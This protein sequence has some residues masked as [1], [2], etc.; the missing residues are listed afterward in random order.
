MKTEETSKAKYEVKYVI[1]VPGGN[2]TALVYGTD[3]TPE[4]KKKINDAIMAKH[5]NVEQVGFC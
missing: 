4:Q 5:S 3:Y 1:A 2:D